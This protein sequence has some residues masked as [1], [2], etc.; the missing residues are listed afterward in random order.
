MV[1]QVVHNVLGGPLASKFQSVHV[2]NISKMPT[3]STVSVDVRD[4]KGGPGKSHRT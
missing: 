4:E 1:T 2:G 3:R